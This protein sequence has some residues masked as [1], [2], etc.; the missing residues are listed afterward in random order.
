LSETLEI[1]HSR[2]WDLFEDSDHLG[3]RAGEILDSYD[4]IL[5]LLHE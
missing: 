3:L 4:R 1:D 2:P 5:A